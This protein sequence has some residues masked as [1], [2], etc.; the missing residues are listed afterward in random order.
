[1][2]EVICVFQVAA[3]AAFTRMEGMEKTEQGVKDSLMEG[4]VAKV[5]VVLEG[6]VEDIV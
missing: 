6:V 4:W 1:M 2:S 5:V 3:A